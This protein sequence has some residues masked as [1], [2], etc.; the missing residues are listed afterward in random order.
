M[1]SCFRDHNKIFYTNYSVEEI[2]AYNKNLNDLLARK[3]EKCKFRKEQLDLVIVMDGLLKVFDAPSLFKF[4]INRPPIKPHV[5]IQKVFVLSNDVSS[6][7]EDIKQSSNEV[8]SYINDLG[9]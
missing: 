4:F 3:Q 6:K 8:D 5:I 7:F 2:K 9:R 1:Y